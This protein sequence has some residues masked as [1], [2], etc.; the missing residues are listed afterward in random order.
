MDL[1]DPRFHKK[2]IHWRSLIR[3]GYKPREVMIEAQRKGMWRIARSAKTK[4]DNDKRE[5]NP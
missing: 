5:K 3:D 1:T 2:K 4:I